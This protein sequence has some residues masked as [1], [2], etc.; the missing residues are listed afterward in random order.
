MPDALSAAVPHLSRVFGE[1]GFTE[2]G[3]SALLGAAA[4][5]ALHRGETAAA[6]RATRGTGDSGRAELIRFFLLRQPAGPR[7]LRELL[8]ARTVELLDAA[9]VLEHDGD[10]DGVRISVD[11]RPRVVGGT[12]RWIF[13]D[14]DPSVSGLVP[15]ADHVPGVGAA[16]LS[17]LQAT[18]T[19]PVRCVLDLGTGCG[20]QMLGQLG[21]AE[22]VTGTDIHTRA[23][24]FAEATL[25]GG[26]V[27]VTREGLRVSRTESRAGDG[28]ATVDLRRGSWYEPVAGRRF[29]RIIANPP[30][31][32]SPGGGF[33]YRDSGLDLDAAS[34][35]VVSG[36]VRHLNP[37]GSAHMLASWV[38]T[39]ETSW[40]QRVASWIPDTG[41]AAWIL[42]RDV[43]DPELYVGTWL[44]DG[45]VDPRSSEGRERT[46]EWLDH[47]TANGVTGVGFGFVA[48][49]RID[50][51]S[52][53]EVTAE[54]FSVNETCG[55]GDEVTEFFTRSAWLRERDTDGI[56]DSRF[57]V[58]PGVAV[59]DVRVTD[60][61]TRQGF[62]PAA[63]RITRT[64]GPR[65]SHDI[66]EHLMAVLSGIHPRG[67][68]L[69]ETVEL[70]CAAKGLDADE[71]LPEAVAA[72]VDLIR[73]GIVL[74][75][76]ITVTGDRPVP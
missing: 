22:T 30:F 66:D 15:G 23:L 40:T 41:V 70:Y 60:E 51:D 32:I 55:L 65:F 20:I 2:G 52:P 11:V 74:P 35:L 29:D 58:R 72:V 4:T 34:E 38:H 36:A 69:R 44:R 68:T 25:A 17:L 76:D 3:V 71:V 9:G 42:Q 27:P 12:D 33:V 37:G 31:V 64:E 5:A 14:P 54:D 18:P 59:E 75:A 73:H 26:G 61:D 48:L 50:D 7:E 43:A 57:V 47:F 1:H 10:S 63:L 19:D 39:E 21:C 46:V 53:S 45:S 67:L 6:L 28:V 62:R 49:Q 13:S 24:D 16:S 56:A 8:G